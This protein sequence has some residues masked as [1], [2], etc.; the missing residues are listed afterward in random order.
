MEPLTLALVI[1]AALAV[2]G[3]KRAST[4]PPPVEPGPGAYEQMSVLPNRLDS[5]GR[6]PAVTERD[7]EA[8]GIEPADVKETGMSIRARNAM[9]TVAAADVVGAHRGPNVHR[10]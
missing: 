5:G 10:A 8:E 3:I 6:R 4:K 2:F 9:A 7:R 1:A